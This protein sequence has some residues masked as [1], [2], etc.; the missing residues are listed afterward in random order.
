MW[1]IRR[2][3]EINWWFFLNGIFFVVILVFDDFQTI[4]SSGCYQHHFL[5]EIL[6]I[7]W[8]FHTVDGLREYFDSFGVVE[9]VEILGNPR[10]LG[11]VVFEDKAAADRCLSHGR[12]HDI[13]GRKCEVTVR[14]PAFYSCFFFCIKVIASLICLRHYFKRKLIFL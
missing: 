2:W 13:N 14:F 4:R 10:G 12:F 3:G 8:D 5:L 9:Q 7:H 1:C 11:F 6:G